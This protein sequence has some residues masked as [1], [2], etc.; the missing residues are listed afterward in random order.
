MPI[1]VNNKE[2]PIGF[3]FILPIQYPMQP[4]YVYLDEPFSQSVQENFDY[5]DKTNRITSDLLATWGK[6][7]APQKHHLIAALSDVYM[8]YRKAPPLPLEEM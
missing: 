4:P 2:R 6:Q 7:Y 5:I 3:K 1:Q 8:L